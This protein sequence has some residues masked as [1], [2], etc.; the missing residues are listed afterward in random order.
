MN[1]YIEEEHKMGDPL[2]SED[3]IRGEGGIVAVL[4]ALMMVMLL[5]FVPIVVDL[6]YS[7]VVAN[8]VQ[9]IA[10]ASAT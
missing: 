7:F 3:K 1:D 10:D 2:R 6:G 4:V 8:E 9:N 5:G